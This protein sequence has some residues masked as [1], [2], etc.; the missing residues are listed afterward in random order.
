MTTNLFRRSLSIVLGL[1]LSLPFFSAM[2]PEV[3][4][5]K[6]FM[7]VKVADIDTLLAVSKKITD[8]GNMPNEYEN[9]TKLLA[10]FSGLN[11]KTPLVIVVPSNGEELQSPMLF[12]PIGDLAAFLK[13]EGMAPFREMFK[14]GAK[15]T[16]MLA[17]PFGVFSVAQLK[18]GVL[19][20]SAGAEIESNDYK[21]YISGM[22]KDV[23]AIKFDLKNASWDS[24]EGTLAPFMMIAAAQGGEQVAAQ[25]EQ[26]L[27]QLKL[28]H[29]QIASYYMGVL[30]DPK[31]ADLAFNMT[32]EA[33]KDT[34]YA[35]Q[36]DLIAS[37]KTMFA[38]FAGKKGAILSSNSV[39]YI[40]ED[41]AETS[42]KALQ[43]VIDG[44]KAQIEESEDE[45]AELVVDILGSVMEVV[46]A[47][48]NKKSIDSAMS[49]SAD[50]VLMI[51]ATIGDTAALETIVEL[52]FDKVVEQVGDNDAVS[53]ILQKCLKQDV[54][55][56]NNFSVSAFNFDLSEIENLP[57]SLKGASINVIW[58]VQEDEAIA[59]AFGLDKNAVEK[60][61][62]AG[63]EATAKPVAV[64][65]PMFSMSL[66]PLGEL[67]QKYIGSID[68]ESID[69][70]KK[71]ADILVKIDSKSDITGSM[72]VKGT[73]A[74]STIL[75][76]GGV[77][78]AL[79]KFVNL[80]ASEN[81]VLNRSGI[82]S[83]E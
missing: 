79:L 47:T 36:F 19:L 68:D 35:A 59:I 33:N 23:F 49:L 71:V 81:N 64:K 4:A 27:E 65:Q 15:D 18:E 63:L 61:F 11:N 40:P 41:Q 9:T 28:A 72:T 3:I 20:A 37:A 21:T 75:V 39:S 74:T 78:E 51:A 7:T 56:I 73:T 66:K 77:I 60:A 38:G 53:A 48:F 50:G 6:P 42:I 44:A 82:T 29:E 13:N 22:E 45:N 34:E 24:I 76:P 58:A 46:E 52:L 5:Q 67:I 31:T 17:T 12:L 54:E 30:F 26:S 62:K 10:N 80:V 25:M 8:L 70:L 83:F 32:I 2:S 43:L 1:C 16:Y 14:K 69:M 55:V 57:A